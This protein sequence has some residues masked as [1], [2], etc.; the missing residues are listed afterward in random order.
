MSELFYDSE[1]HFLLSVLKK[2]RVQ[3]QII[4]ANENPEATL[5]LGLRVLLGIDNHFERPLV[6]V[7]G[8]ISPNTIHI[9]TDGYLCKYIYLQLPGDDEENVLV[10]GP[11]QIKQLNHEE[12]L[13]LAE[14]N[15]VSPSLMRDF[16]RYYNGLPLIGDE[17]QLISLIDTFGEFIWSGSSNY[18]F[19][20]YELETNFDNVTAIINKSLSEHDGIVWNSKL[21]EAR[22]AYEKE[23]LFAVSQGNYPKAKHLMS[24]FNSIQIDQRNADPIRDMKNYCITIN[25]LFRKSVERGGVHPIH[26]D[27]VSSEFVKKIEL[28]STMD[29]IYSLMFEM[30]KVYCQLVNKYSVKDY[31]PTVQKVVVMIESNLSS[32]LTLSELATSLNIN[33]SYLSTVF[34][35]ETGKTVT[36]YVNEKRIELAQELLRT[37][38]LQIQTIAQYCGIIDVHYFTRLF[39]KITGVSPKQFREE[40]NLNRSFLWM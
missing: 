18:K 36:A 30:V 37:T 9:L 1:L 12:L 17:G 29:D 38:N 21:I 3:T 24:Q 13:E 25:T 16:E 7:L 31:S 34:K 39:K 19:E 10:I 5:D 20:E 26:I 23:F 33:A 27:S 32:D 28:R 14:K 35:K 4:N 2:C 6:E 11:Y 8:E 40:F 15:A 22:Y